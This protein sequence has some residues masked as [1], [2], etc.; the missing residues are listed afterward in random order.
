MSMPSIKPAIFKQHK[1]VR[2]TA[3]QRTSRIKIQIVNMNIAIIV[4]LGNIRTNEK[5]L[6]K[7]FRPLC[8]ELKHLAHRRV[9]VYVCIRPLHIRIL[10]RIRV[11][12]RLVNIHEVRLR[13]TTTRPLLTVSNIFLCRLLKRRL[14]QNIFYDILNLLYMRRTLG[15]FLFCACQNFVR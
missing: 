7:N 14:H 11:A 2:L 12:N 5:R 15:D 9:A 13:L 3:G 4:C 10:T 6:R 8:A 1:R